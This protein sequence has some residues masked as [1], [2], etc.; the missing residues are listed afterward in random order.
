MKIMKIFSLKLLFCWFVLSMLCSCS[1][2]FNWR[3][4]HIDNK[5]SIM[6]PQKTS[7]FAKNINVNNISYKLN[8][9]GASYKN[10][11]FGVG[12]I[13]AKTANNIE[14]NNLVDKLQQIWCPSLNKKDAIQ[15]KYAILE[16]TFSNQSETRFMQ[17]KW[18]V[19]NDD[20]YQISIISNKKT[21]IDNEQRAVFFNSFKL[22][23]K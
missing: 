12:Y 8:L 6:F 19:S 20:I 10:A 13:S 1:P 11:L 3:Q 15:D 18:V 23:N 9:Q 7:S 4:M 2:D 14:F 5:Y 21:D 22:K 16:C 17:A